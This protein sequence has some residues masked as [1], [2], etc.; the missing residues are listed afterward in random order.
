MTA[1]LLKRGFTLVE[2]LVVIAIIGVLAVVILVAINPVQQLARTRD[3]GRKS[4]VTQLG[5]ALE[6]YS[7]SRN[8]VY[9]P[10]SATWI[11]TLVTAGEMA[12]VPAAIAY[13]ITGITACATNAQNGWC[14]DATTAGG[15]NPIAAW[16]RLESQTSISLCT[17][18]QFAW[19]VWSTADGRG[20]T[21]CTASTAT[22]APGAQTFVD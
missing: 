20:G 14:Y 21:I 4:S 19:F 22:P 16:A 11:T 13:T 9:V 3:A 5:H 10:E 15:G 12:V 2:L 8:G 7:T 6:A 1:R 18:G 17:A